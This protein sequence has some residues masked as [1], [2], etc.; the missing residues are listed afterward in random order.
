MNDP[1]TL[2]LQA[3]A[4]VL[5]SQ[6]LWVRS[7]DRVYRGGLVRAP[8]WLGVRRGSSKAGHLDILRVLHCRVWLLAD[9]AVRTAHGAPAHGRSV[10]LGLL[11]VASRGG[12]T[13]E[14]PAPGSP[15]HVTAVLE[16]T[17]GHEPTG[18]RRAGVDAPAGRGGGGSTFW[19]VRDHGTFCSQLQQGL[20]PPVVQNVII[21]KLIDPKRGTF[22]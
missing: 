19:I 22:L 2:W 5:C 3:A 8:R 20:S 14:A 15:R 17:E 7:L 9:L 4:T 12:L 10:W 6:K 21:N 13:A 16:L 18:L 1:K 11:R